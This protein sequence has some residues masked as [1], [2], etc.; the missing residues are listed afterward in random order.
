M[1]E[2]SWEEKEL[3]SIFHKKEASPKH[4]RIQRDSFRSSLLRAFPEILGLDKKVDEVDFERRHLK[5][6]A[7]LEGVLKQQDRLSILWINMFILLN[8][9]SF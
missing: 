6:F 8:F 1:P 9:V 4:L 3:P 5:R 2:D 7:S